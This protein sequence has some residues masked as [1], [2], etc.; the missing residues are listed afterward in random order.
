MSA[1]YSAFTT[2]KEYVRFLR[3]IFV[4]KHEFSVRR[5]AFAFSRSGG[6]GTL[7][8]FGK[9]GEQ[10]AAHPERAE[11]VAADLAADEDRGIQRIFGNLGI[12]MPRNL[13]I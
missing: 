3:A 1:N 10:A 2:D 5:E 6:R 7:L 8:S 4:E 11:A 9:R 12:I 13:D